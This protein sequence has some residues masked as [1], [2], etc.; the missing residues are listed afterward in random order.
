MIRTLLLLPQLMRRRKSLRTAAITGF[1]LVEVLVVLFLLLIL[2]AIALPNVKDMVANQLVARSARGVSAYIDLARNRAISEGQ[3]VGVLI[4]RFG[5]DALGRAHSVRMR[6]LTSVP[7]YTGDASN[8]VAVVGYDNVNSVYYAEFDPSSNPLMALS[9][10]MVADPSVTGDVDDPRAP[11]RN[12]DLIEFP[13]GRVVPFFFD[14]RPL[15]AASNVPVRITFDLNEFL[16][17]S[18]LFPSSG[19]TLAAPRPVKFKIHRRPIVSTI[20]PFS[21]PRGIV[22]DLNYS[23]LGVAGNQ[24]APDDDLTVT[25]FDLAIVFGPDGKVTSVTDPATGFLTPPVGRIFICLGDSDG[26]RPDDL[27]SQERRATANLLNLESL[28]ILVD[29]STGRVDTAPFGPV[30]SIPAGL[31]TDTAD[32]SLAPAIGEA[33]FLANLSDTVDLE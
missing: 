4:E 16:G 11:I 27:F 2:A 26:V 32:A 20:T 5:T 12:R 23:G 15:T 14:Y 7:P 31:I 9:A 28:W 22:L 29:P 10:S 13:G 30:A 17:G 6:Q 25:A 3:Q 8:A 24:F 19:V 18:A 33:R 21:L 1:T